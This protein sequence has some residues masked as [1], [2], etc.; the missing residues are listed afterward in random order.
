MAAIPKRV[1][2]TKE[3]F[4]EQS[5]WIDGLIRPLNQFM[6]STTTALTS[7]LTFKNNF[8]A[9]IKEVR[10]SVPVPKYF[11]IGAAGSPAF[12]N[13]WV[14]FGAGHET[15]AY[16]IE[17]SGIVRFKGRIKSG[18]I[19]TAAF[20]LPAGYRPA[21]ALRFAQSS[22]GAFGELIVDSNGVVNP[23]VGSN[24][25]FNLDGVAFQAIS[26]ASSLEDISDTTNG[27]SWPVFL[28]HGLP[29]PCIG[30]VALSAKVKESPKGKAIGSFSLDWEDVGDGR[31]KIKHAWGL[32]PGVIYFVSV[33]LI[34]E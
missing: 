32:Q 26:V 25:A 27:I 6:D 17:P 29:T 28:A 19:N 11:E 21:Q 3:D 15:A 7:G 16:R 9:N 14:N 13:S 4:P 22:N 5:D 20:T 12:T 18:T 30:L 23:A 31:V 24:A 33:L 8:R 1:V 34:G 10:L 2:L